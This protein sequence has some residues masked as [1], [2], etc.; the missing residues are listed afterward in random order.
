[1]RNSQFAGNSSG[2]GCEQHGVTG[3]ILVLSAL[4]Y[5]YLLI[6]GV[7]PDVRNGQ[8][9]REYAEGVRTI[10]EALPFSGGCVGDL[11]C[12][13]AVVHVAGWRGLIS[14]RAPL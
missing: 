11:V 14:N 13:A 8:G 5:C 4:R 6:L 12:A 2:D 7:S 1:M 9:S 10:S 3:Q